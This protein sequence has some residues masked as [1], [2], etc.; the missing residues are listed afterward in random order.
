MDSKGVDKLF[1]TKKFSG[2]ISLLILLSTVGVPPPTTTSHALSE[3]ESSVSQTDIK[4][5]V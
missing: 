2:Y 5:T 4:F 1:V 3:V